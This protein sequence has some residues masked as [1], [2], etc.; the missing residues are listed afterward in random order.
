MKNKKVKYIL[1][2]LI[3]LVVI[4]L[5]AF[6]ALK[7]LFPMKGNKYGTRLDGI[8]NVPVEEGTIQSIK[9]GI[10]QNDQVRNVVYHL[11]GRTIN[12]TITVSEMALADAK[13]LANIV[14]EKLSDAHKQFYDIQIFLK[15]EQEAEGFPSIGY[16]HRTSSQFA[17]SGEGGNNE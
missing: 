4:A 16:R 3:I 13:G 15:S 1:I 17:W 5:L 11:S 2:A 14:L 10:S 8:E 6:L 12:I 9:D 7:I